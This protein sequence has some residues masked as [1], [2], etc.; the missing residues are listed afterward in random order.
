V[1][2]SSD[3]LTV[4]A[5]LPPLVRRTSQATRSA[6]GR[7]YGEIGT[8]PPAST[9][10]RTTPRG[11]VFSRWRRAHAGKGSL[12]Q[13]AISHRRQGLDSRQTC[14]RTGCLWTRRG[15]RC[16]TGIGLPPAI[17]SPSVWTTIL[18]NYANA[19]GDDDNLAR[20]RAAYDD[21]TF[22]RLRQVK[23]RWDPENLFHLNANI[24][25]A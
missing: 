3:S 21:E 12:R 15:Q 14:D 5:K 4:Y 17:S 25:P 11:I 20:V 16:G 23:R 7:N 22:S 9:G 24:P 19:L 8:R 18:T 1:S 2:T 13:S 6:T 10:L